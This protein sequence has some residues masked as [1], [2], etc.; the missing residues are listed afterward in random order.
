M[1]YRV[2][3]RDGSTTEGVDYGE[4]MRLI[5]ERPNDWAGVQPMNYGEDCHPDNVKAK[6]AAWGKKK[7]K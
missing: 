7:K 3:W 5:E 6:E 1:N 4:S 2:R